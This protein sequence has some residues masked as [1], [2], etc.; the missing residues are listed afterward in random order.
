MLTLPT[1]VERGETPY[2]AM[3]MNVTIPFEEAIGQ[4]LG[5]VGAWLERTGHTHGPAVFRYN[6]IDMPRL[7]IEFGFLTSELLSGAPD[8]IRTGVLPAG[9]Y[10]SLTHW[11]HYQHLMEATAVLIGWARQK[12]LAWDA[13][14]APQGQR[15]ASRFE[16][17]NNAPA[18]EPDPE[19][20]E[21]Q[22]FIKVR[23]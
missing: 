12:D 8:R 10:A 14:E 21:T 18:D 6:L 23:D 20:W 9:R 13:D 7:G 15:F 17:Y 19:K 3:P 2:A 1:I 5:E 11:G 22:I 4:G 16:L